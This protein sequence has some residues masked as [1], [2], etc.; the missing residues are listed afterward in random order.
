MGMFEISPRLIN[1]VKHLFTSIE[2]SQLNFFANERFSIDSI[3]SS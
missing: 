2:I 1:T 3:D